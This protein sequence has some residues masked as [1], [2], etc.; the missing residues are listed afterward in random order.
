M[1]VEGW[2]FLGLTLLGI[3][4]WLARAIPHSIKLATGV[5]IGLYLTIIGLTYSAGIGL[6]VGA[7]ATPVELA[8]CAPQYRDEETGLCPSSQ[9]M[10][11]PTMW[12]GIFLAGIMVVILQMYRVKGAII[13]GILL[14][15]II[16]WPRPTSVTNFPYTPVGNSAFDFF[17]KVVTFHPIERILN[18]Q[19]W[20]IGEYGGQFGL[21][22][23]TFLY[24]DILDA[25]G[26]L[27]SMARFA[28]AIDERTQDF[29]NSTI[30]YSVDA[31]G[32]SIG[33]LM[34]CPPVTAYI[35]SGAGISEGGATGLTSICTGLCFFIA[36]FFAPIF[37][38]IPPWA[39]GPVLV[40]VSS[41]LPKSSANA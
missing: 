11:N 1:F 21:A 12:I 16:S 28:G 40:I 30:A 3:R 26:T 15:S 39:T 10:R 32:I 18:V 4:Q 25:T 41:S 13:M 33:A 34:G 20:D 8:G 23:I 7:T 35:E 36:I 22:F 19:R 2:V 29:E 6:I 14:V 17:K 9:K 31:I 38:S 5:G 27:Y 37:A 24:V